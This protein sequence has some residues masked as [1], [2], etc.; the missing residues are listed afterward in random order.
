MN[1]LSCKLVLL[2][3]TGDQQAHRHPSICMLHKSAP[4]TN[5]TEFYKNPHKLV[6]TLSD[7]SENWSMT[8]RTLCSD[9]SIYWNGLLEP[10]HLYLV[11]DRGIKERDWY[12]CQLKVLQSSHLNHTMWSMPI[13]KIEATT[14]KSLGLPLIPQLFIEEY[15]EKQ[16]KINEVLIQLPDMAEASVMLK[17][18]GDI[19]YAEVIINIK[20]KRWYEREEVREIARATYT[21]FAGLPSEFNEWF[22][23]NY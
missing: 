15:I 18:Y 1:K 10:M 16:G 8:A 2:T 20:E 6:Y 17:N 4:L 5:I 3:K 19:R 12:I 14:D 11:S 9:K 22:N 7:A 23:K 13:H 21:K